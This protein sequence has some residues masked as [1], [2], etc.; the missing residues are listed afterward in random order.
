MRLTFQPMDEASDREILAWRYDEP[1]ALYNLDPI[2]LERD[3]QT[4]LDPAN[5]YY[6]VRD[7]HGDPVAFRCFGPDGQVPGGDYSADALD[8]GGG[9]RPD[10]TGRGLG[11]SVLTAGLEFGRH[12]Y[13]PQAFRVT[14]AA[15]N[16]RAQRVCENAGFRTAQT[17]N[18]S[19]DGR[20]FVV[21]V[22]EEEPLF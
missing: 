13:R 12:T 1:Y 19:Y 6:S 8:T 3:Q 7:E 22:R 2:H 9:M 5:A 17:F 15:F 11:L 10:L 16:T 14:V 20:E 21:M 4:Y 18:S